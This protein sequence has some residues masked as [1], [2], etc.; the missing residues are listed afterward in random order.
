MTIGEFALSTGLSAKALRFYDERG[1][2][3]P[4]EVDPHSGYRRYSAAQLK[5]AIAIRVLRA[6]GMSLEAV[7]EAITEPDRLEHVVAEHGR[8]LAEERAMQDRA[9]ALA[10]SL[11]PAL[12][13]PPD[14]LTREVAETHW[15]GVAIEID[16]LDDAAQY[17]ADEDDARFERL[18]EALT[19]AGNP[20]IGPF[21]TS[22]P[23]SVGSGTV[24]VAMCWP[25]AKPVPAEFEVPGATVR[26]GTLAPGTEA[27]L[28]AQA[29]EFDDLLDD[30][31]G[32]GLPH[33]ALVA[34]AEYGESVA[35]EGDLD[36]GGS[37]HIRQIVV[38]GEDGTP[39]TIE[40]AAPLPQR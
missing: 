17:S 14:V 20:P 27:Y 10:G 19:A 26:Q 8:R 2:L 22:M 38:S 6:A 32:G 40:L 29:D 1:L 15:V 25:V 4:A 11:L 28:R 9:L 34:F 5:S 21:W 12:D 13:T 7:A 23:L 16:P 24:E 31:P 33:P 18:G 30:L 3:P 39:A 37:P 35:N 36:G